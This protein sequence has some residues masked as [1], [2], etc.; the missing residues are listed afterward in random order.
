ML[1]GTGNAPARDPC[2][3]HAVL[4]GMPLQDAIIEERGQLVLRPLQA[5]RG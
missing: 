1:A 5:A 4:H 3:V 2:I